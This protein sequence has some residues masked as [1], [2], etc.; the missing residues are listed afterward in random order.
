M[1]LEQQVC[2]LELAKRLKELGVNQDS[3]YIWTTRT[4]PAT[5]WSF[6]RYEEHFGDDIGSGYDEFS[7]FTVAELGEML[8]KDLYIPY[9]GNSGK[10]RKYPQHPHC[11]FGSGEGHQCQL[12]YTGG[13]SQEYISHQADT[14][15]NVRAKMLIYLIENNLIK[16]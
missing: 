2:S 9:K 6:D 14:E 11:F 15:A 16:I 8:P 5:L 12:N 4:E 10:K 3:L 13:N 7:A 1:K